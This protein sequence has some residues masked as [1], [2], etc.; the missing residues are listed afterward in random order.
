MPDDTGQKP[1]Q[2][3]KVEDGQ[4]QLT[5]RFHNLAQILRRPCF[6]DHDRGFTPELLLDLIVTVFN[7]LQ[8]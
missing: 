8:K 5:E 6:F 1:G 4:L 7:D 3:D 2:E